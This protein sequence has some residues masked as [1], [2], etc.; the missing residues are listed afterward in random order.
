MC[1]LSPPLACNPSHLSPGCCPA[2]LYV[3]LPALGCVS[4]AILY[5]CPP[6]SAFVSCLAILYICL[7]ALGCCVRLCPASALQSL[8]SFVSQLA[9]SASALQS[10]CMGPRK[11]LHLSPSCRLLYPPL[12]CNP[13]FVTQLWAVCR[14]QSFTCVSLCVFQLWT[15]VPASALQSFTCVLASLCI[16]LPALDCCI[17]LCLAILLS[18]S[19]RLHVARYPLHLSPCVYICLPALDC[20]GRLCLA[21]LCLPA[22][23]VASSGCRVFRF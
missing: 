4:L 8:I 12:P 23:D 9:V 7:S 18:P 5:I 11:P 1:L 16:C 14:L 21:I 17:R 20:C 2:I 19:S 15:A 10:L 6:V 13:L 22:L 3:C